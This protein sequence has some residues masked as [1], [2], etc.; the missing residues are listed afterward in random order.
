VAAIARVATHVPLSVPANRCGGDGPGTVTPVVERSIPRVLRE[1]ASLQP[2]DTAITFVD[3]EQDWAGVAE[4]LTWSQLY[5]R[6][7][8]LGTEKLVAIIEFKNRGD[9]QE[10]AM[11]KRLYAAKRGRRP[12]SG[13]GV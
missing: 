12:L 10:D 3:Y 8:N 4:S 7:L 1:H 2:N 13:V 11:D 9:C 5:R 6:S